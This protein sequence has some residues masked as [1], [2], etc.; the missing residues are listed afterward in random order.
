VLQDHKDLLEFLLPKAELVLQVNLDQQ[1]QLVLP[2]QL[3]PGQ[4]AV[5][6]QLVLLET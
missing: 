2:A 5:K 1:V 3:V 4:L 6:E